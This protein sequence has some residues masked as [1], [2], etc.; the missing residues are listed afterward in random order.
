MQT[1]L[2]IN[3]NY[4]FS[5]VF[6]MSVVRDKDDVLISMGYG[7]YT[8]IILKYSIKNIVNELKYNISEPDFNITKL[9][10]K[11]INL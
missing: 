2:I 6:P 7:D 1:K 5:L 10:L 11:I 4:F 8:N 9:K 3:Y